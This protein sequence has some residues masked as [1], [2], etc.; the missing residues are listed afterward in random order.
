MMHYYPETKSK[1]LKLWL[2]STRNFGASWSAKNLK[3]ELKEKGYSNFI[4]NNYQVDEVWDLSDN[5][6]SPSELLYNE[7]NGS[8]GFENLKLWNDSLI[9]LDIDDF[10]SMSILFGGFDVQVK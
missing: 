10:K 2:N 9:P 4:N 7:V 1:N 5:V 6:A 8:Y 3:N